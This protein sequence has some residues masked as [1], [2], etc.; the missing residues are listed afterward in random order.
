[1][2][3]AILGATSQ[4]AKDLI[5]S[6]A[7][8]N[9]HDL[10]LFARRPEDVSLWLTGVGLMPRYSVAGFERFPTDGG[11]DVV[12]NFVGA[13]N[14][15][16]IAT[17]GAS[18]F[19]VTAKYDEMALDYMRR[20]SRCRYLFLSSGA[21]YGSN[22]NQ[23]ISDGSAATI[24]IND[25]QPHD[26]YSIAKLHAE[27]RHRSL[28]QFAIVDIR[29]FSY[30]SR[31]QDISARFLMSDILRAIRDKA[32][33]ETAADYIVRDFMHPFDFCNLVS[34]VI[35]AP[36][37][38][39]VVD[40]YTKAP[41]D[42]PTLLEKMHEKFGLRYEITRDT[43]DLILAGLKPFYYSTN[44]RAARFGYIPE[45]TSLEGI[46]LEADAIL[47]GQATQAALM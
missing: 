46:Y 12:L 24:A 35:A 26:W 32:V 7:A 20:H 8:Q 43:A 15:A 36:A 10:M 11:F 23:P 45:L 16:K 27:G 5:V 1:V 39:T 37:V 13:G 34:A 17:M 4:I 38:N 40:C 33:L 42:K 41:I 31:T 29:V 44:S 28:S 47:G 19:D 6:L 21:A 9:T 2:R 3:I 14:P 25:L 18:I 30:F 22:F